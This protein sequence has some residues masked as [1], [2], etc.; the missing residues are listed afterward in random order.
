[1]IAASIYSSGSP[2]RP[3]SRDGVSG[4]GVGHL[5][6]RVSGFHKTVQFAVGW[7]VGVARY[8]PRFFAPT[9]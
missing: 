4:S 3:G 2:S 8:G 6:A 9:L 5:F 1:M 7:S